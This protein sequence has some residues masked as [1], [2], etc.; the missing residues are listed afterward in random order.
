VAVVLD[1]VQAGSAAN[2]TDIGNF[3]VDWAAYY[4]GEQRAGTNFYYLNSSTPQFSLTGWNRD[5]ALLAQDADG[6]LN[7]FASFQFPLAE[8]T[9]YYAPNHAQTRFAPT[10]IYDPANDNDDTSGHI[11]LGGKGNDLVEGGWGDDEINGGTDNDALDGERGDD[12]LLGGQGADL[13]L[14]GEGN[15]WIEGGSEGDS[16]IGEEGDDTLYGGDG[17]DELIGD[18]TF[19]TTYSHG[20]D[21][22]YGGNGD[23]Q[24]SGNG[25]DDY[26][27]GGAGA[28]QILGGGGNDTLIGGIDVDYMDGGAGD[29]RYVL[30][31]GDGAVIGGIADT[32]DD[33]EG[34]NTIEFASGISSTGISVTWGGGTDVVLQYG[35]NDYVIVSGG[36]GGTVANIEFAG[37]EQKTMSALLRETLLVGIGKVGNSYNNLLYAGELGA[38][39]D[40]QGGDD[41]LLGGAGNEALYGGIGNDYLLGGAGN[42]TLEGSLGSDTY[43]FNLGD[44]VD[45]IYEA[46]GSYSGYID[47]LKFGVGINPS[48]IKATRVIGNLVLKH[49]NGTDEVVI[50][51]WFDTYNGIGYGQLDRVEFSDGTQWTQTYLNDMF[52]TIEG[53]AGPDH[54]NGSDSDDTLFGRD[55]NDTL[56]GGKGND[57]LLGSDGSDTY[58]FNL[59][60]GV[61]TIYE[62]YGFMY[63]DVLKFGANIDANDI[64]AARVGNNLELKHANGTDKVIVDSWF[65]MSNGGFQLDRVEF[66]DGTQWLAADIGQ[67]LANSPPTGSVFLSGTAAQGQVLT[68]GNTLADADGLGIIGY[69]WQASA[70]GAA[71]GN[72]AEATGSSFTL[73]EAQVGLQV[74]VVA[75]YTDGGGKAESV[76][77][78]A[79][80]AVANVNDAPIT[81]FPL[82]NQ[83]ATQ[84]Q[85]FSFTLP[86]NAFTDP[87]LAHGD[88]L[89]YGTSK[90]DGSALPAWL[91]FNPATKTFSGTPANSDVGA[92]SLKVTATDQA[93][94]SAWQTFDLAVANIND[95]PTLSAALADQQARSGSAFTYQMP[96]NTFVDIDAG[97]V[98]A[99]GATRSDGSALP[100][101]LN[102]DPV[103]RTFSGNPG[104]TDVG[105]FDVRVVATD[106]GGLAAFDVFSLAVA[107]SAITGTPGADILIG[108]AGADT[109]I[110]GMGNDTYRVNNTGDVVTENANEGTDTVQS[111]LTWTL[112]AN[113]ENLTLTGTSA[114]DG[115]GNSANNI[116]IGNSGANTLNGGAGADTM[117]GGLGNDVYQVD[118]AGDT[119]TENANEGTD[120]VQSAVTYTL[121][122]NV[123][124][125]TLTGTAAINGTGNSAN[126]ILI[127]NSGANTLNGGA[128]ADTMKG[129]LGNDVYQVDSAGDTVAENAN[130]GTDTVQ[131]AV[132][133]TLGANVENL[134]LTGTTSINGTGNSAN[135]M[136]TGNAGAN[137]L[138]GLDGNDILDGG[139][140]ADTL[141]GGMGNDTY[142]VDNLG[143]QI[144][145]NPG[146]GIDTVLSSIDFW[147][148]PSP[149]GVPVSIL[150]N[151]T[152]TGATAIFAGGNGSDNVL[153]GNAAANVLEGMEGNDTLDGGAGA[154]TMKG[155]LGNDTYVVD[156]LGDQIIES[157]G[158]GIDTVLS[159]IDFG[160]ISSPLGLPNSILENLTLTGATAIFAGGNSTNN[161][162]IG[163][164]AANF[165]EGREG[166][167]NLDGGA[168]VDTM[169]GGLGNDTYVVDNP[170]DRVIENPG[171]GIDIVESHSDYELQA[172]VEILI[173]KTMDSGAQVFKGIGNALNNILVGNIGDNELQGKDGNDTLAGGGG[174]DTLL[175][176]QGNDTYVFNRG[177]GSDTWTENDA[178]VGNLDIAR[179]GADVAYDQIWFRHVGNNLEAQ[180]I[181]TSDKAVIKDW[182]L[183]SA[184]HIERFEAGNGRVLI[185][186]QV[187]ALVQ[188]MAAF[189]PPG[190][191]QTTLPPTYQTVLAPVL[192]VNWQ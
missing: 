49:V 126:N 151:L 129:G 35:A 163:N 54:L 69:Q 57:S 109:L 60:D 116:L 77:S 85:T 56:A 152:L 38:L 159:S 66:A 146:E 144:I 17:N 10:F 72:L 167:D 3:A 190:A 53:T 143:D 174:N 192:A 186:S 62:Y 165:L 82:S 97:D 96:A 25:G 78:A 171:E 154:D 29:D 119:V 131:S 26:L 175:G 137:T 157:P 20:N 39:L 16:L 176:G 18:S 166:D 84:G 55:G 95:A 40:G 177:D 61:D 7:L 83:A 108:T 92:L 140:G 123:E 130:E 5:G 178:T 118:N 121:G 141:I 64:T 103:M 47:V 14:G 36:L 160:L 136:L 23:D 142:V 147:L 135:N 100:A 133:Y 106:L 46:N 191:G 6:R 148:I 28:D 124:N 149:P 173:L 8:F 114:I 150:E 43:Q 145:E 101:W 15:D 168:G 32:I 11:L 134:T 48:D 120:T 91:A 112:G 44:G 51:S 45:T 102:F 80:A 93:G 117:K 105:Q 184:N 76:T 158:E 122:A 98:L 68:A 24:L 169:M 170:G 22:L 1:G 13:I 180:V 164:S 34:S 182:Y 41:T 81:A 63:T 27:D 59:G 33:H 42:D 71:W 65:Q 88:V 107:P 125:L 37:G 162:L 52:P 70:D 115:T 9:R 132:T 188:A 156:N 127:G 110:G 73:A 183:G 153:I 4:A 179:F 87:D 67:M 21:T 12:V 79:S 74:R 185:D 111:S 90:A 139:A 155:G 86:T 31:A 113:L 99:F 161:I 172:E 89:N 94:L 104:A 30:A 187:D 138:V 50:V 2:L 128:G 19:A 58:I 75:S 189:A 181:G